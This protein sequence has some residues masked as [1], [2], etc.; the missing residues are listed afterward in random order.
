[1]SAATNTGNRSAATNTGNRSAAIVTGIESVA[2]ALGIKSKAKGA[3]GCYI[4]LAEHGKKKN[5]YYLKYVKS[6]KVDGKTIEPNVFYTL[7]N[8]KFIKV[9][10]TSL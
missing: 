7:L 4:V 9:L 6:H 10:D 8:G 3:L 1:M 5:K 2:C